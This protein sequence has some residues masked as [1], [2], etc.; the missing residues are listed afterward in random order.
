MLNI[1]VFL[2][3]TPAKVWVLDRRVFK[4]INKRT[5]LQEQD[6]NIQF[7]RSVDLF[8]ELLPTILAKVSDLLQRVSFFNPKYLTTIN[9][10]LLTFFF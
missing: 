10:N 3:L 5:I 6:S 4:K 8:R 2:V 9:Q 1:S 7:L